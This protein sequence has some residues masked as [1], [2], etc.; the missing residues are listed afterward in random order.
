MELSIEQ[1]LKLAETKNRPYLKQAIAKQLNHL[2]DLELQEILN[3]IK[4]QGISLREGSDSIRP[5]YEI[6]KMAYMEGLTAGL[7]GGE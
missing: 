5:Y 6:A 4:E 7:K 2:D 3:I 1:E